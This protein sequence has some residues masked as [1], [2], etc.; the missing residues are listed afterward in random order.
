M[1]SKFE[2][3]CNSTTD[4]KSIL[5]TVDSY[6]RKKVLPP[7]WELSSGSLYY[8]NN[9]G[10]CSVL[11]R[12]GK[13][14]GAAQ[15]STP[16]SDDQYYYNSAED[17]IEYYKGSTTASALNGDVWES[18]EDWITLKNRVCSEQAD[19][20]RSYIN[21]PIL[22]RKNSVYQ[23]ASERDYDWI[24]VRCNAAL[25][26]ADLIYSIDPEK[27]SEIED[28][29]TN[30]QKTGLLDKLKSKE[31]ALW[32]ET[33]HR[34]E[35]GVITYI[36]YNG[37]STGFISDLKMESRPN[38]L[39]DDVRAVISQGGTFTVGTAN[40][41]VKYDIYVAN[42][43]GLKQEKVVDGELMNGSYQAFAYNGYIRWSPGIFTTGDEF[44]IVFQSDEI[45]I[46][47][48]KSG[49]IYR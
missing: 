27:A 17:R 25:A 15:S 7:T 35:D 10:F 8:L 40:T 41:T 16:S 2:A 30:E 45:A 6:D 21:R 22:K 20:I 37:S 3:Y 18:G 24:V 44:S 23:G 49:Q 34:S 31:Y 33:T 46:G 38:V 48:V 13:D 43:D 42:D 39:Y 14:L 5:S 29:I 19:R 12:N 47:N 9:S 26:V 1:A 36:S 28:R 32:N 4:L 11:F